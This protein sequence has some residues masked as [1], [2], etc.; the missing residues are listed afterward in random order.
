[1]YTSTGI[2]Q[3]IDYIHKIPGVKNPQLAQLAIEYMFSSVNFYEN[4]VDEFG[5]LT[6]IE[7]FYNKYI[8]RW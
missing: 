8:Q 1:L 3:K 4:G 7:D 5:L 6:Q 2:N